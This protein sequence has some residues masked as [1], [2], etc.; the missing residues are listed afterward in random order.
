MEQ[1]L[2]KVLGILGGLGPMATVYFYEMLT[3]HTQ[4]ARDQD[5][6]DVIINSRATTPDRT[7]YIL[8]QSAEN[9]FDIMAADAARLVTFGADVIAIPC[10]TAHYFYDRLN[11]TIPIPIL[12]MVEETV[13]AAK[14]LRCSSGSRDAMPTR[15]RV[16]SQKVCGFTEMRPTPRRRS[17]E[18][19]SGSMVSGRPAST[20]HSTAPGNCSWA[21]AR[22][23]S[24]SAQGMDVGVPP[25]I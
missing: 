22:I 16:S 20:V 17:M 14:A 21:A 6:I 15:R 13:L 11:E 23:L 25:P 24:R 19:F 5:H 3:R 4:A 10:N 18:S 12:N 1:A 8:G 7:S 9:P 2:P